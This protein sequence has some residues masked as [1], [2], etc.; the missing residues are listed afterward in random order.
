[1]IKDILDKFACTSTG[2]IFADRHLTVGGSDIG[3]C[4]RKTFYIK[5]DGEK[6]GAPRDADYVDSWGAKLRGSTFENEVWSPAM[7]AKYGANLLYAGNQQKTLKAGLLSATPDGLLIN[8]PKRVLKEFGIADIGHSG[9]IVVECKTIDPRVSLNE[10]KAE[11]AFQVQIQLGLFHETTKHRPEFAL[12]S[13]A[14]A[15]FWDEITEFVIKRD[16]KVF[17][18]ANERARQILE[19]KNARDLKPE[20]WIAGG[21]ECRHCPYTKA[22]GI[23]RTSLPYADNG[24]AASPEFIADITKLART[25]KKH[26]AEAAVAHAAMR[27]AQDEIRNK[28]REAGLRRVATNEI[29]ITWSTVKGRPSLDMPAIRA[30][31]AAAGV[32]VGQYETVGD[33]SDR[34]LIQLLSNSSS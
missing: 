11:H 18:H 34:L 17:A 25:A 3:Q 14:D 12:I 24:S 16:P 8:Q 2:R 10:A 27:H 20:G 21:N 29:R 15:S 28:L 30:A 32:D 31:A 4:A 19:A 26:E 13:Y 1:V 23:E 9:E 7:R 33:P 22:C 6:R 5:T